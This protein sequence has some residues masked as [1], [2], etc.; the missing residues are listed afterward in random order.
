MRKAGCFAGKVIERKRTT[1]FQAAMNGGI[2]FVNF[3]TRARGTSLTRTGRK[4][5]RWADKVPAPELWM[6]LP[7]IEELR[8]L[9][10]LVVPD[11]TEAE[12]D[13]R[14]GLLGRSAR[15]VLSSLPLSQLQMKVDMA[16]GGVPLNL[17]ETVLSLPDTTRMD[18]ELLVH[19]DVV[20][21]QVG[22]EWDFS[23]YTRCFAS[24]LI[25]KRIIAC[26]TPFKADA[27]WQIVNTLDIWRGMPSARGVLFEA[28][29]L[30]KL[31]RGE[32][33]QMRQITE[34]ATQQVVPFTHTGER[35]FD[36]LEDVRLSDGQLWIPSSQNHE[37]I[38]IGALSQ[39]GLFQ[40][41]TAQSSNSI[42]YDGFAT[43][44]RHWQT[45]MGAAPLRLFLVVPREMS[46]VYQCALPITPSCD[47]HP[48]L[49]EQYVAWFE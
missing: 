37:S 41:T 30:Q 6:P 15:F 5:A 20:R 22:A 10:G 29:A 42:K 16:L 7:T 49:H 47:L 48:V 21:P 28:L 31:A 33:M 25:G 46:H 24:K 17:F 19:H 36:Q 43:A 39:H 23:A 1:I 40:I 32:P 44:A 9:K 14:L 34:T 3:Q 2:S 4:P 8:L 45:V 26:L 11:L 35:R 13:A 18:S 12:F 38:R 27:L